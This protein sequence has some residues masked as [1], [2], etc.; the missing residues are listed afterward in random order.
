[1]SP[2]LTILLLK[3]VSDKLDAEIDAT[4]LVMSVIIAVLL[5]LLFND[6]VEITALVYCLITVTYCLF[7]VLFFK[8]QS[9]ISPYCARGGSGLAECGYSEL[10][11]AYLIY[12]WVVYNTVSDWK[13]LRGEL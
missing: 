2:Y 12:A 7:Y 3:V 8:R 10:E 13:P 1:M 6:P 4:F 9:V 11:G 5:I